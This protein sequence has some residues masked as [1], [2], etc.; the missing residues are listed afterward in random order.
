[1]NDSKRKRDGGGA[2]VRLVLLSI[3]AVACAYFYGL[4]S[5]PR[6]LWPLEPLRKLRDLVIVPNQ[7]VGVYDAYGRLI[8]YPDKVE[9]SCPRQTASTAVI[10]AIGQSNAANHAA[11]RVVTRDVGAVLN[12]FGGKCYVASSP[13]LGATG[14][15]GEFLTLLADRLVSDGLYRNVVIVSSGIGGSPISRWQRDGD[16]NEMLLATLK[17]LPPGYKVTEI[18]WHQGESD[19]ARLTSANDYAKSFN[20]LV[21]TLAENGIDAPIYASV[22]T[23]C[24]DS[25]K[26]DNPTTT[27]QRAVIDNKR[28][29]LGADTD[30]LLA[31]ADRQAD[32]CHFA[33]SGQ[34]KTAESY[35]EAIKRSRQTR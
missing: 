5:Y 19:F 22:S 15:G 7:S 12:Y 32:K 29:F 6:D 2:I 9:V 14:E 34:S 17:T 18:V 16:L 11:K 4:Y 13:L 25:W 31:D 8:A 23:K 28:I 3:V 27:G 30:T 26:A 24:G 1:M 21:G 33:E 10:L 20:A 35:A